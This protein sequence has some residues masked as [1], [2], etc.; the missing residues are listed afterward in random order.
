MALKK[1]DFLMPLR[2]RYNALHHFTEKIYEAFQRKN[3]D[4]RLIEMS[5]HFGTPVKDPADL[6]FGLNGVPLDENRNMLCDI[7]GVP[8]FSYLIDPPYRFLEIISSPNIVFGCDD[9]YCCRYLESFPF[10]KTFFFPHGVDST[11]EAGPESEKC[12]DVVMLAA[13]INHIELRNTWNQYFPKII[14]QTMDD[15]IDIAFSDDR[16]SF[17]EAFFIAYRDRLGLPQNPPGNDP[18]FILPLMYLEKYV[19][20]RDR[21]ELLTSLPDAKIHLFNGKSEE[22]IGWES[23]L[24]DK[25]PNI[26]LHDPVSYSE[27]IEIMKKSKIVLNSFS[28]NKEGGHDRIFNGL[29]AGALVLTDENIFMKEFFVDEKNILFY[30][31]NELENVNEKIQKYLSN[32]DLRIEVTQK[33]REEVMQRHTWDHRVENLLKD[34]RSV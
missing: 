30:R 25:H 18:A 2:S 29:A 8:H 33:G 31:L 9:R 23:I 6:T 12:Y 19:K 28:K 16:T 34:W 24:Q 26:I 13:F 15:A 17:I 4:C 3:F 7:T 1:I 21:T 27:G 11:L 10:R 22:G 14:C 20:G 32:D 5:D